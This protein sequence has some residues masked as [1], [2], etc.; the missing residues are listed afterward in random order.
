MQAEIGSL[1][2]I[3][4]KDSEEFPKFRRV[5]PSNKTVKFNA[6]NS[7]QDYEEQGTGT[8]TLAHDHLVATN[9]ERG[10][11]PSPK[12]P[13][14][15]ST[16]P[17]TTYFSATP[18]TNRDGVYGSA[19]MKEGSA[20]GGMSMAPVPASSDAKH[21]VL[22]VDSRGGHAKRV[23]SGVSKDVTAHGMLLTSAGVG[24]V[25]GGY[26]VTT[27]VNGYDALEKLKQKVFAS[28]SKDNDWYDAVVTDLHGTMMMMMM[29]MMM[30]P[31][32]L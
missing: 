6:T 7:F 12:S 28:G 13:L 24:C 1:T 14:P 11:S 9:R 5:P 22:L 25:G 31:G 19:I 8:G 30:M 18:P 27:A 29:M 3:E 15:Q 21:R 26:E 10:M 16:P 20:N 32:G 23:G 4:T 17:T 2:K